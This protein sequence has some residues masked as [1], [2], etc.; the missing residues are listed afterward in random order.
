MSVF[1]TLRIAGSGLTAQRLRMDVASS[2]LANAQTTRTADGGPYRAESAVFVAV[3]MGQAAGPGVAAMAIVSPG[4]GFTRAYDPASPDA[5][6]EGFVLH[7]DV[8]VATEMADLMGAA[9]S[10]QINATV[11]QAV[12]QSALDALDLGR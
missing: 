4:R 11:V 1:D 8:D 10:F 9:R 7:P 5:D 3:P 2:N 6:A 12:K